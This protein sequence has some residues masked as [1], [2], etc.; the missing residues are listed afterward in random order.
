MNGK[1]L[2]TTV[3]IDL[4]RGNI[5]AADFIAVAFNTQIPLF[6]SVISAME[7]I[8]GCRDKA[9]VKKAKNLI[10]SF[11]LLHLSPMAST[12]AY[13]LMLT[14]SK[15]HGL[16]IPDAL[17]AA[18]AIAE[19]LELATDNERHFKIIPDLHVQRPY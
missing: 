14:Y 13:E 7:L 4:S 11:T 8:A 19:D 18:T 9:E 3:L 12:K 1:L 17:I 16:A 15:G 10:A 6:V 2:D 5:A